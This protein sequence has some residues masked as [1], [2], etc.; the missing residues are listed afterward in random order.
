M[1]HLTET[2][3]QV[4]EGR[5]IRA[6][7]DGFALDPARAIVGRCH[8]FRSGGFT[9]LNT[10]KKI[11]NGRDRRID[12]EPKPGRRLLPHRLHTRPRRDGKHRLYH[13]NRV[14]VKLEELTD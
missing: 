4:R 3:T 8:R 14:W 7:N 1:H 13:F 2:S 5:Q 9:S 11:G 6:L 12:E 10:M